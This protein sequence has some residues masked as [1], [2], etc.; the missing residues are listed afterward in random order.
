MSCIKKIELELDFYVLEMQY[1]ELYEEYIFFGFRE[2]LY[3]S[4]KQFQDDFVAY[5]VA[6]GDIT[7]D[8]IHKHFEEW[9]ESEMDKY[10]GYIG[11]ICSED[12]KDYFEGKEWVSIITFKKGGLN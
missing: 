6:E 3:N 9:V 5:V 8:A 10:G 4:R 7:D 2:G 12:D 1:L 11:T